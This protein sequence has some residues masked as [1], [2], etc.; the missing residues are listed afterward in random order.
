MELA[1]SCRDACDELLSA[2]APLKAK[3]G[4]QRLWKSFGMALKETMKQGDFRRL[5]ERIERIEKLM[6]LHMFAIAR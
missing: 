6:V 4:T 3:S 2:F 5:Q 1:T